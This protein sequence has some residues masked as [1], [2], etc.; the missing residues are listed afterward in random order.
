AGLPLP[1]REQTARFG[2]HVIG[3]H[4]WYKRVPGMHH[5]SSLTFFLDPDAGKQLVRRGEVETVEE[6]VDESEGWHYSMMPTA[7]YL[8][9]FGH[10]G[11]WVDGASGW[12]EG[13]GQIGR[14]SCRD[15]AERSRGVG[16]LV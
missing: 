4:S 9:R 10:W 15:R 12:A 16:T 7:E 3:A 8:A 11:Y 13:A 14:A 6:I 1:T 2:D 5:E